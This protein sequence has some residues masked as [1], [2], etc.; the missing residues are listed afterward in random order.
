MSRA[1]DATRIL[2]DRLDGRIRRQIRNGHDRQLVPRIPCPDCDTTGLM[3]RLSP[4]LAARV[5]ECPTC[6]AA[7]PRADVLG[8]VAA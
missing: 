6:G 1:A 7:W 8:S 5:I 2:A 3:M 4:P